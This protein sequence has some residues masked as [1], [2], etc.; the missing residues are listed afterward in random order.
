M[1]IRLETFQH[2]VDARLPDCLQSL[3]V[4]LE[5][6]EVLYDGRILRDPQEFDRIVR[7]SL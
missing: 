3:T 4:W 6:A 5:L 7:H 2:S 1:G